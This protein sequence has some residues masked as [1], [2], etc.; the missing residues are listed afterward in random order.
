VAMP[1][2]DT[3][4]EGRARGRLEQGPRVGCGTLVT[5]GLDSRW[6]ARPTHCPS[7]SA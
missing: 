3:A 4:A 1:D 7:P 6:R 2:L 5:A